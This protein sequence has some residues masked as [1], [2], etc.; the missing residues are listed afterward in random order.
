MADVIDTAN[1]QADY[2][3]QIALSR[4]PRPVTGKASAKFCADCDEA[5]PERR[6]RS[7]EGCETCVYCQELRE[8]GR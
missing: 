8:R 7:I 4:H 2:F 3:L 1:E 5:I 6:Q